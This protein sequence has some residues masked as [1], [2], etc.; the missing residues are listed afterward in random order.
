ML[1]GLLRPPTLRS[2][3]D[4]ERHATWLE[5]FFDLVFVVAVSEL[6]HALVEHLTVGGVVSFVVLFVPVWWAWIGSTF[7]ATRFDTDDVEYRVLTAVEMFAVIALAVNI[8]AGLGATSQGFA[9]SYA[10][11]RAVLV[12]KYYRAIRH[13]PD[14]RPLTTRY[15]VGFGV[16]ALVWFISAFV[17]VPFRFAL[18]GI[19]ILLDIGTPLTAGRLHAEIPPHASHLPE[20]FGLFTIIV[21]GEAIVGVVSGISVQDWTPSSVLVAV[22]STVIAFILWWIYFDNHDA[23]AVRAAREE[24]RIWVYQEWIYVHFPL[25]AGITAAGVGVLRVFRGDLDVAV[26]PAERWLFAGSLALCLSTLGRL[27]RTTLACAGQRAVGGVQAFYRFG[28][29]AFALLVGVFGGRLEPSL[30][31]GVLAITCLAQI[32]ADSK[33]RKPAVPESTSGDESPELDTSE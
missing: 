2:T 21:L 9:L 3:D 28:T 19:G 23:T 32:G 4:V 10:A 8:H 26:P 24:G 7:Y 14:A 25:V 11:V 6:A 20:R 13:V 29:S 30:F 16:A 5:L 15:A 31:V 18:W 17:P 1:D 33:L 22:F 12:L 27:H